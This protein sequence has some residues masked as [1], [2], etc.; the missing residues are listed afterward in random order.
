MP[1]IPDHEIKVR[2]QGSDAVPDPIPPMKVGQTVRY[3]G[4]GGAVRIEFSG[5]SPFRLDNQIMTS[6]PGGVVHTLL[7]ES[8][9][10]GFPCRCFIRP[11]PGG[12]EVGW[13]SNP[14]ISGGVHKVGHGG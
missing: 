9:S 11:Q 5:R 10:N 4:I 14:S 12:P 7:S 2:L 8:D 1:T 3:T 13:R 6:V